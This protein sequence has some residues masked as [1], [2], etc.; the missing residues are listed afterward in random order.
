MIPRAKKQLRPDI[1]KPFATEFATQIFRG[2]DMRL[3]AG[4]NAKSRRRSN[5]M[6]TD[7]VTWHLLSVRENNCFPSLSPKT[8]VPVLLWS[9]YLADPNG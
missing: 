3:I 7:M 2:C 8:L 6:N 1:E 9:L 4:R 5:R